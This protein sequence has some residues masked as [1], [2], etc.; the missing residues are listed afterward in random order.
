MV[1]TF[2]TGAPALRPTAWWTWQTWRALLKA[3]APAAKPATKAAPRARYAAYEKVVLRIGIDRNTTVK[4][5]QK[6]LGLTLVDGDFGPADQ[7]ARSSR[8]RRG[9]T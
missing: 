4:V 8:S 2:Q 3:T 6:A 5:L 7:G 9:T 1:R